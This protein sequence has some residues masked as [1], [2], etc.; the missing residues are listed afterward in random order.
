MNPIQAQQLVTAGFLLDNFLPSQ[1]LNSNVGIGGASTTDLHS[2]S[3]MVMLLYA[4]VT[5]NTDWVPA[6]NP[7]YKALFNDDIATA[8]GFSGSSSGQWYTPSAKM[9]AAIAYSALDSGYMP[10]GDVAI[11]SLF[12]DEDDIGKLIS[13]SNVASYLQSKDVQVALSDIAVEY[14]GLLA[15]NQANLED[16][17]NEDGNTGFANGALFYDAD[18]NKL[19]GNFSRALW[20]QTGAAGVGGG[21]LEPNIVGITALADAVSGADGVN[22]SAAKQAVAA[23]WGGDGT[24]ILGGTTNSIVALVAATT[25]SGVTLDAVADAQVG[26]GEDAQPTD[27]AMLVGAGGADK[28]FG[29]TGNDLLAGGAGNDTLDGKGGKDIL[30]GGAGDDTFVLG[31]ANSTDWVEGDAGKDTANYSKANGSMTVTVASANGRNADRSDQIVKVTGNGDNDFV[32]SVEQINL[33]GNNNTVHVM[34]VADGQQFSTNVTINLGATLFSSNETLDFS[35]YGSNVYLGNASSSGVPSSAAELFTNAGLSSSAHYAFQNFTTLNLGNGNNKVVLSKD[36]DIYLHTINAGSGNN[37][38][39]SDNIDVIINLGNGNNTLLH[40][41]AGSIINAGTGKNI[42]ETSDDILINGSTAQDEIVDAAGDILHGAIGSDNSVNQLIRGPDGTRY[43]LNSEGQLVI[44]D[45]FGNKTFVAGYQGGPFVPFDQQTDGILVGEADIQIAGLFDLKVPFSQGLAGLFK[46]Y[47]AIGFTQTGKPLLNN[48]FDPLVFDLTGDGINLTGVGSTPL[49]DINGTGFGIDTG[50]IQP[51]DGFLVL[52]HN[53]DGQIESG[54]FVGSENDSGFTALAQ[55]DSNGD[56]VIDASDPIYSQLQIW[57]DSNGNGQVD[58]GELETLAEAGI[59]SINLSSTAQ[60]ADTVAG[61]TINA[62]GSFTRADGTTG[63]IADV[64]LSTDPVNSQFLGNTTVSADAAATGVNLKGYGTL[65]DLQVAMTLD[66]QLISTVKDTLPTLDVID[67]DQLRVAALPILEGWANAVNLPGTTGNPAHSDI[68]IQVGTDSTGAM[69]VND[70]AYL[71]TDTNGNTYYKLASG[72]AV[73]DAG[74]NSLAQPTFAQVLAQPSSSNG[75]W[76]DFT[77]EEIAFMERYLGTSLPLDQTPANPGAFISAMSG[78][79][80]TSFETMN[81]ETVRLA[82]Q[83]PLAPYFT[84]LVYDTPS[85]SFLATTDLDLTP[86]Y[87]AIFDAAPSDAAG[88]TAWLQEWKPIVDVV[89]GDFAR[90]QGAQLSYAYMFGNMV[91]A[92]EAVNLP[93]DIQDA[94]GALGVPESEIIAGASGS[95]LQ[96]RNAADIFYLSGGDQT[97]IGG[98]SVANYVMG[99]N[100]G[101][102]V[103]DHDEGHIEET[104]ALLRFTTLKSTDVS[105]T[106]NGVDLI[107]TV[108]G[109]DQ[110]ITVTGEFN[111]IKPGLFGGNLNEAMGVSEIV[112][113]DGVDWDKTDIA[114]AVSRPEPDQAVILGTGD[115]DVLDPGQ[116]GVHYLSGGDG[117]DVYKFGLGYGYD[118]VD[119]QQD[120]ILLTFPSYIEFGAGISESDVTFSG[121]AGSSDLYATLADGATLRIEGEYNFTQ[122]IFGSPLITGRVS[123]FEFADGSSLAWNQIEQ[124]LIAEQAAVE[125]GAIYGTDNNDV[126]DPG[127]G[128]GNHYLDAEGGT[129]TYVFG[130]GYGHDTIDI[131]AGSLLDPVTPVVQFNAD[132]TESDVEWSQVGSS[133]VIKLAGTNDSLTV[134][135]QFGTFFNAPAIQSFSFADGTALSLSD[136]EALV[137]A[138]NS[139]DAIN[140]VD[141]DGDGNDPVTIDVG[142]GDHTFFADGFVNAATTFVFNQGDGQDV[143][144]KGSDTIQFGASITPGM[145]HVTQLQLDNG[146]SFVNALIFTFDGSTDR[147]VL[148]ENNSESEVVFAD[149]T[150]WSQ[151]DLIAQATVAPTLPLLLDGVSQFPNQFQDGNFEV[152]YNIA[153]GYAIAPS[154]DSEGDG[155]TTT[156]I[157]ISGLDP[158]DVEIQRVGFGSDVD[159]GSDILIS[160][161]GSTAGGLLAAANFDSSVLGFDQIVFDDGTVWTRQ[162]IEQRLLEQAISDPETAQVFGFADISTIEIGPGDKFITQPTSDTASHPHTFI[163]R[164]GDGFDTIENEQHGGILRF[165]DIDST[166]V[167]L[168]RLPGNNLNDLVIDIDGSDGAPEGQITVLGQFNHSI[169]A[170]AIGVDEIMFADGVVWSEADIEARLIA[171]EE[172]E[173]SGNVTIYGFDSSDTLTAG[174]GNTVL[175]GGTGSDTFVW[176]PGDG[177]TTIDAQHA[178]LQFGTPPDVETLRLE[179]V[180]PSEVRVSRDATPGSNDLILT[181]AGQK[182][183]ILEDQT[184]E[185]STHIDQVVF[186]NGTVWDADELVFIA[187]GTASAPNGVNAFSFAGAAAN[188]TISGTDVSD[189]YFWG[190]GDGNDEIDETFFFLN[191]KADSVHLVGLNPGDLTFEIRID[192]AIFQQTQ[193]VVIVDNATGE[194]LTIQDQLNLASGNGT[195]LRW[196]G[197]RS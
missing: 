63:T 31:Y 72:A 54:D 127:A 85:N 45:I 66:P 21:G 111:G 8:L 79:I 4:N 145:V 104:D 175:I 159:S 192:G 123:G 146:A 172:T 57:R 148:N 23:V 193:D 137:F 84:G 13:S 187:D 18:N 95:T 60:T 97:A 194:T 7:L 74:G 149:G 39:S 180:D 115:M 162:Q 117:G 33:S 179:G 37:V 160:A 136:I 34:P 121:V 181:V 189:T 135:N 131:T 100:F 156:T 129:D 81:I 98:G 73:K 155:L 22:A 110:Q 26:Q 40:A 114:F 138:P 143:I 46:A 112:F 140:T 12:N 99:G 92:Y 161:S 168:D 70:F 44:E 94:A 83:G 5:N 152:D 14:A 185:G 59:T 120:D 167:T 61:N 41:G 174:T 184:G 130:H 50:W 128:T 163:Y 165:A 35:Q 55:Y 126:I 76:E 170:Q 116:G 171:N 27:G 151:D 9:M 190:A 19:V 93:L 87:Q 132:V 52:D 113:S 69:V 96:D 67:L 78:F 169:F 197:R 157:R 178:A 10:Y 29:S 11:A 49:I 62:T 28:L 65:T 24:N 103:I 80:T 118:I 124:S 16:D 102:D 25:D 182:P 47:N 177:V 125:N 176:T 88:A 142:S 53:G 36:A 15:T 56:G 48:S 43:G 153:D 154:S 68:A 105:A 17:D 139:H 183:I 64:T 119:A 51:N 58:P 32:N 122:T 107:L 42:F 101:Q 108:N 141:D 6:G 150:T 164:S 166:Q 89:L 2:Q 133:L 90:S 71:F 147:I 86:M 173:T 188:S 109:T 75:Q 106:R 77:G 91:R 38:I 1:T 196:R 82:M 144:I 186:D 3:L 134:L 20:T 195:D 191:Q 30:F 158:A